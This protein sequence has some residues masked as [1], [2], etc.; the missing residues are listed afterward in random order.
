MAAGV[1]RGDAVARRDG[2]PPR[3][4]GRDLRHGHDRRGRG[5]PVDLR[6]AARA[7]RHARAG[8][9][10]GGPD[11]DPAAVPALR[12]RR[13]GRCGPTS[14]PCAASWCWATTATT[15]GPASSTARRA[16]PTTSSTQRIAGTS[17]DDPGLVI[18]SSGTTSAPKGMLHA[19]RAPRPADVGAG[20][21][22]RAPRGHPHVDVAAPVLDGRLQHR[23]RGHPRG[24]RVLGRPGDLRARRGAGPHEQGAGHR[25][26]LAAPP[27]GHPRRA[28][29]LGRHRPV[30]AHLRVRQGRLRPA[31]ERRRRPGAGSCPWATACRRP[32]AQIASHRVRRR[33]GGGPP[34]DRRA[35]PR[36]R[37]PRR[38]PRVA[39]GPSGVDEEGELTVAGPD[40]DARLPR[41]GGRGLRRRRRLLPHRRRGPRRRGRRAALRR[42]AQRDD[43][44]RRGQRVPG[45]ARGRPAGLRAGEAEPHRRRPRPPAR[46]DGDR[47]HRPQ[48]RRRGHRGRRPGLP[49]RPRRRRT[50]SPSG[51]SSSPRAR[52]P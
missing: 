17:P 23:G 1:E 49:P 13:R 40:A 22:L 35:A 47:L 50:R 32:A 44:D 8:R 20:A 31:P 15:A 42:P 39:V 24:G 16:S 19:H 37:G 38:R 21:D 36:R 41:H 4:R 26:V 28:P 33:P 30:L 34:V 51:S 6:P 43:Q 52:C 11:P 18:F 3:G 45:R 27:D 12:R 5:P 9:G 46:P 7:G 29:G 2:Q 25:A 48:G 10:V 14:L